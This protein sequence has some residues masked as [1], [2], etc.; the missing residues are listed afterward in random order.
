MR[1]NI[2]RFH[3]D[4]EFMWLCNACKVSNRYSLND[5][6]RGRYLS[7]PAVNEWEDLHVT[8]DSCQSER[9]LEVKLKLKVKTRSKK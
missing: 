4:Y 5:I 7:Y 6:A 2:K 9:V 8:C 3:V 1:L